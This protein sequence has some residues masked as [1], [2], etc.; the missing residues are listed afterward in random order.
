MQESET[1]R[2]IAEMAVAV[3]QSIAIPGDVIRSV[4][5]HVRLATYAAEQGARLVL[6]PEL[7]VTGYSRRLARSDA[8]AASDPRLHALQ[9][10]ADAR[11]TLIIAG[12]PVESSAGL[13]IGALC[14]VPQRGTATYTKR[15]LHQGEEIAFAPG[16]GG[17]MLKVDDRNVCVAICAE[18]THPRHVREAAE[19]GADIY[20]A[21]CLI[22][23]G[24]Y[25]YDASVL[26]GYSREHRMPVLMA[27]YGA[28]TSEW[29][30]AGRSAIWS[31]DGA[32][33]ALAPAHGEAVIVAKLAFA[34]KPHSAPNTAF[35]GARS[36]Q[37]ASEPQR[38]AASPRS[39][40]QQV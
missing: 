28:S 30:S 32:Q 9:R 40:R 10:L 7:S 2:H 14:F 4:E 35:E 29:P 39:G 31:S 15:F 37:C 20:A 23:P 25:Q 24:G 19:R 3:A 21:S 11:D 36:G 18:I 1:D 12:A 8:I 17:D 22:T 16:T 13:H 34:S 5:E 27:N 38:Q 6:F 33:L 26:Q